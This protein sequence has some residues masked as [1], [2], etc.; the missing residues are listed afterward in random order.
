MQSIPVSSIETSRVGS[1]DAVSALSSIALSGFSSASEATQEVFRL[2]HEIAGLRICVLSRVDFDANT[3]TVVEALDRAGLG[4]ASGMVVP[5]D[6][7][8]CDYVGRSTKPLRMDDL[9]T[10]PFFRDLPARKKMGLRCYLG[11]PLRRSD[12]T[13]WGTL[14]ATDTEPHELSDGQLQMLCVFAKMLVLEFEREE[15]RDA[16][17]AHAQMLAERLAMAEALEEERLRAVR[18]ETVLEAAATVSHE[19]NNPLT[20]LQLR[21]A[22]LQKRCA[23]DDSA[24][25]DDIT[26]ATEAAEEIRQVTVTLRNVVQPV[27]THYLAGRKTRM[28]DL[29]A[30]SV[31][32]STPDR[33]RS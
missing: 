10:Y 29:A 23:P 19:V 28:I 2:I 17:A 18:L 12:G 20:V 24:S 15:Q 8:P 30:S 31:G 1:T 4:V 11:V 16:I 3:L 26:A 22:R 33:N 25:V 7:M 6:S 27:S 21:L 9:D 32:A 14:A 13:V 5:A